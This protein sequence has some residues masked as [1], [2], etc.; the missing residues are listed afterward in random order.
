MS[1]FG[2]G[3]PD[4]QDQGSFTS[5]REGPSLDIVGLAAGAEQ[6]LFLFPDEITNLT[7]VHMNAEEAAAFQIQPGSAGPDAVTID[8]AGLWFIP[9]PPGGGVFAVA[10]FGGIVD[11]GVYNIGGAPLTAQIRTET[12]FKSSVRTTVSPRFSMAHADDTVAPTDALSSDIGVFFGA[13]DVLSVAAHSDKAATLTVDWISAVNVGGW[14][15]FTI[16]EVLDTTSGAGALSATTPIRGM[17]GFVRLTN[18]DPSDD[19]D[20]VLSTRLS[21]TS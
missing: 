19:A 18:N 17:G 1:S 14:T 5:G 16:T 9:D 8:T 21:A 2:I 20:M 3:A 15:S 6:H 10:G 13:Y 4:A 11:V 12:L 7:L